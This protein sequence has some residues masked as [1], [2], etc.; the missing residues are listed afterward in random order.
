MHLGSMERIGASWQAIGRWLEANGADPA[1]A[2]REL[3]LEAPM[4]SN[5]DDWVTELQQPF[6]RH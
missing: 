5:Q 4:G 3:Y 6:V 2:C 1:G